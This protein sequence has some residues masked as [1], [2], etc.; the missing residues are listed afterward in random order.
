MGKVI[1]VIGV[2]YKSEINPTHIHLFH[3]GIKSSV[4]DEETVIYE[5]SG[6]IYMHKTNKELT[7]KKRFENL[8]NAMDY[9]SEMIGEFPFSEIIIKEI[10]SKGILLYV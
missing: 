6:S 3:T 7:F 4:K 1:E 5:V 9:Q 10:K 2:P 8:D